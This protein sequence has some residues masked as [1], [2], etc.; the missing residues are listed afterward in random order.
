MSSKKTNAKNR[1]ILICVLAV[2]IAVIIITVVVLYLVKPSVFHK[3][4]GTGEHEWSGWTVSTE[5]T[6]GE[7]GEQ[8]RDCTICGEK[9]TE[10]IPA[11][12]NHQYNDENICTVCGFDN[13]SIVGDEA[14]VKSSDLSIHFIELGN[15]ATGDCILIDCGEVEV[16]I[17]CG[18]QKSSA[19][20]VK[21]YLDEYVDGKIDYVIST[22]SDEDHIAGFIG[23]KSGSTRTG[24]LYQ[25]QVDTLIKFD[26]AGTDGNGK[27]LTTD[28]GNATLYSEYLDAVEY[29]KSQGTKVYT[30]SQCYDM[31]GGAQ[32][33]YYLDK[34]NKISINILYN[35]YYYNNS[36]DENNYSVVT[37]LTE[38]LESGRRHYLFTGDLEEDGESRMVDYYSSPSNSKTEYDVLPEVELYKAGHHGSKTSS[39][40][41]LLNAIKPKYVAVCCCAGSPEYTKVDAN[42]FPT[43]QMIDNVSKHTENIFVTTLATDLPELNNGTF[44]SQSGY[45]YTSMNGNIVFYS[46]GGKLKLW[47]SNNYTILK[48]TD[49]FKEHRTWNG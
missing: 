47:C 37:L 20:A 49:W 22:H 14:G 11:T 43:Q 5:A 38:Q 29:A 36:G 15:K 31:T 35:Y 19:P 4:L 34:N 28:K 40:S 24:I 3:F 21:A 1:R 26:K 7:D 45:G 12:G 23:N 32:R 30:A 46:T 10:K 42:T 2:I 18:S 48:D 9:Q 8:W 27:P 41:K 44:A 25:Y 16:L 6:C 33:Q 13:N 39:T 17:D